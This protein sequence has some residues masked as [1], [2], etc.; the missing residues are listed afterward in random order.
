M[1]V[2]HVFKQE[3]GFRSRV[4]PPIVAIVVGAVL[5]YSQA[6]SR[7]LEQPIV[8]FLQAT[9]LLTSSAGVFESRIASGMLIRWIAMIIL[10]AN[11]TLPLAPQSCIMHDRT[12]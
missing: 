7:I 11:A 3:M 1:V 10:C 8:Q 2:A 6:L 9:G 4:V 12:L 5:W